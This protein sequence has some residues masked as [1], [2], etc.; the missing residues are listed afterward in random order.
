MLGYKDYNQSLQYC[1]LISVCFSW[2]S[3]KLSELVRIPFTVKV[4]LI[5]INFNFIFTLPG[6]LKNQG[7]IH[8]DWGKEHFEQNI[9]PFHLLLK[10]QQFLHRIRFLK[11]C[12]FLSFFLPNLSII[13]STSLSQTLLLNPRSLIT[14]I[15]MLLSLS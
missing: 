1:T 8:N 7:V 6:D 15:A 13:L 3:I 2:D 10:T 9:F 11:K 12:L 4:F 5:K 14:I